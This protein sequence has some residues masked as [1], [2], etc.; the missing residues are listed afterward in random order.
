MKKEI[1]K[2]VMDDND[3]END[4]KPPLYKIKR[5]VCNILKLLGHSLCLRE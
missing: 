2:L 5:F 4:T 1:K 3:S